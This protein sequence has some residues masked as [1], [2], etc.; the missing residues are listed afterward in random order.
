MAH[1]VL[2]RRNKDALDL[3]RHEIVPII[4]SAGDLSFT[5]QLNS[6]FDVIVSNTEDFNDHAN[7]FNQVRVMLD[8]LAGHAGDAGLR[9]LTTWSHYTS[10]FHLADLCCAVL[11][12]LNETDLSDKGG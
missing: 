6:T 12:R 5:Y 2:I 8:V 10:G 11:L 3:A 9:P 4:G 7:H 1:L